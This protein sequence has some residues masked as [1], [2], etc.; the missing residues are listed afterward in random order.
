MHQ[1]CEVAPQAGK[2]TW[3]PKQNQPLLG[4]V[5]QLETHT[6]PSP[7]LVDQN[8]VASSSKVDFISSTRQMALSND[9]SA[10]MDGFSASEEDGLAATEAVRDSVVRTSVSDML[11]VECVITYEALTP[12]RHGTR[13]DSRHGDTVFLEKLRYDTAGIPQLINIF[14]YILYILSMIYVYFK[15]YN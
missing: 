12:V 8:A 4:L 5:D 10:T 13:Y 11:R 6:R 14:R 15:L 7:S 2:G 3:V 1:V 9:D